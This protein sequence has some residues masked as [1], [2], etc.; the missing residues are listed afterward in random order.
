MALLTKIDKPE[1]LNP[2][3]LGKLWYEKEARKDVRPDEPRL[4]A[5]STT[6]RE[7]R[8]PLGSPKPVGLISPTST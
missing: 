1:V 4:P 3:T 5:F 2:S 7:C 6:S 8:V